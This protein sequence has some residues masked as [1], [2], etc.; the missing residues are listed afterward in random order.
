MW[1]TDD[2]FSRQTQKKGERGH[3]STP[4]GADRVRS[5]ITEKT[6][7]AS[8]LNQ[9]TL[10]FEL[11]SDPGDKILIIDNIVNPKVFIDS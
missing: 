6:T 1:T 9:L 10:N 3:K 5:T 7:E 2:R 11:K 4:S 8:D